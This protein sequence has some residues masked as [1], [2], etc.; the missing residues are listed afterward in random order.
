MPSWTRKFGVTGDP[1]P[2]IASAL[3]IAS[4]VYRGWKQPLVV[5]SLRDGD[6]IH[7]KNSLHFKGYAADLRTSTL[8]Q[9]VEC[10]A[11]QLRLRCG[12][13]YE[14]IVEKDHIHLEYDPKHD[15]GKGLI[16]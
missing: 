10:V 9:S 16:S 13:A 12:P 15:G 14:V 1:K 6:G 2:E 5:T 3:E 8:G 7:M 11:K 4:D